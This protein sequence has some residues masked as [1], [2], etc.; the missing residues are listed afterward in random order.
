[1]EIR[2]VITLVLGSN[3]IIAVATFLTTYLTTRMQIKNSA[4]QFEKEFEKTIVT[5]QRERRREVRSEPLQK[6]R[7]ELAIMVTKAEILAKAGHTYTASMKTKEQTQEILNKAIDDWERYVSSG[8][9]K[10][11]LY[12]QSDDELVKL[13][14]E[15]LFEY[16]DI[17]DEVVT[18]EHDSTQIERFRAMRRAEQEVSPKVVQ[19]QELINKRLE[20]L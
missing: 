9:F 15:I 2:D 19:A 7:N 5:Y 4:T 16:L 20:E 3:F 17:Y 6:L 18:F 10:K 14:K 11:I 1:M 8:D 13:I 12:L